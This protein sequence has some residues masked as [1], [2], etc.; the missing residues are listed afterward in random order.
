MTNRIS[1]ILGTTFAIFVRLGPLA[2]MVPSY[3]TNRLLVWYG[4]LPGTTLPHLIHL[5]LHG[6]HAAP[7]HHGGMVWYG[8]TI[9]YHSFPPSTV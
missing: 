1:V 5:Y 8:G 2:G 9:P 3:H 6:L 7:Y 4:M